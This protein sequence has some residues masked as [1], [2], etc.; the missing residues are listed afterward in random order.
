M[1][2]FFPFPCFLAL[3]TGTYHVCSCAWLSPHDIDISDISNTVDIYI[4]Y[5]GTFYSSGETDGYVYFE[6][7]RNSTGASISSQGS[8]SPRTLAMEYSFS[9]DNSLYPFSYMNKFESVT[10]GEGEFTLTM[11]VINS[12]DDTST[13]LLYAPEG[14]DL[15]NDSNYLHHYVTEWDLVVVAVPVE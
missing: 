9:D 14:R 13:T 11:Y 4:F 7:E 2:C 3:P 6:L 15:E 5:N 10:R 8:V 12:Y 1:V